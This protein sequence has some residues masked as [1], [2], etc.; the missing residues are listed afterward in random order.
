SLDRIAHLLPSRRL[1]PGE[2]GRPPRLGCAPGRARPLRDAARGG[3]PR[4]DRRG[5]RVSEA[6]ETCDFAVIGSGAGGATAA[7][8]LAE[9]GR[10]VILLEEGPVVRDEDR[11]QGTAEAFFRLFR[12][13]GTQVASGRS[14]I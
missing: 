10:D 5:G 12:D 9:A 13:A 7:L 2:D 11:G 1:L 3:D 8:V 4:A 14:V 6:I